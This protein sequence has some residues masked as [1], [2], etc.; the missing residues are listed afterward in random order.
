MRISNC[1]S[2]FANK[3]CKVHFFHVS[4]SIF[5]NFGPRATYYTSNQN[6]LTVDLKNKIISNDIELLGNKDFQELAIKYGVS[7]KFLNIFFDE[8]KD[9]NPKPGD[10]LS[11]EKAS[12]GPSDYEAYVYFEEDKLVYQPN[13]A[14]K[15]IFATKNINENINKLNGSFKKNPLVK[16]VIDFITKDKKRSI[17]TPFS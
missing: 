3:S 5:G 2:V 17:C 12:P 13:K 9:L 1:L 6:F 10:L 15:E 4:G 16:N 7:K 14:Y 11:N 8:I